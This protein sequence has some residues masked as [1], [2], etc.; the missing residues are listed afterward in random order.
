MQ[1]SILSSGEVT[2][3]RNGTAY[4]RV[5]FQRGRTL[6]YGLRAGVPSGPRMLSRTGDYCLTRAVQ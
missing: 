2:R 1:H 5:R 3:E 4:R 6:R